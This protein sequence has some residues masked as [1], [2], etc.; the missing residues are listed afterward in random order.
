MRHR[1]STALPPAEILPTNLSAFVALV[2]WLG[3]CGSPV[4]APAPA[5]SNDG[6]P[7][8]RDTAAPEVP[9][10]DGRPGDAIAGDAAAAID[11]TAW[12]VT[13][14][15]AKVDAMTSDAATSDAHPGVEA[16]P[17]ASFDECFA[18]LPPPAMGMYTRGYREV[19][20]KVSAD[21]KVRLRMA[22]E[23]PPDVGGTS[24]TTPFAS[25]VRFAA[26]IG[27]ARICVP[28]PPAPSYKVTHHNYDDVATIHAADQ[29]YEISLHLTYGPPISRSESLS[30]F[31]GSTRVL[32]PVTL[33]DAGCTSSS[34]PKC[35]HR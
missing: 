21:G 1:A 19:Q 34:S 10:A 32:G 6:A 12:D 35:I 31:A 26:Q 8:S 13:S 15:T 3:A 9:S 28:S 16:P 2:A 25:V 30:V 5:V 24:G 18:G 33:M 27:D 17:A 22:I 11:G 29:R 4:A 20:D 7:L 14:D 23:A